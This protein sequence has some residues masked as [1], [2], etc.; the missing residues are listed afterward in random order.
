MKLSYY[1]VLQQDIK[2]IK[3][4]KMRCLIIEEVHIY[5]DK[6]K[7]CE[8]VKTNTVLVMSAKK[9]VMSNRKTS[10]KNPKTKQLFSVYT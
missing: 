3:R 6:C 4:N 1:R 2:L 8:K 7:N 10:K 5:L 9:K